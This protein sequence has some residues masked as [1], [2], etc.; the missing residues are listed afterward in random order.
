MVAIAR[1]SLVRRLEVLQVT[2]LVLVANS[3]DRVASLVLTR[4]DFES[5]VFENA[6]NAIILFTQPNCDAC[7]DFADTWKRLSVKY[8]NSNSVFVGEIS[9]EGHDLRVCDDHGVT[10]FPSIRYFH[11]GTPR[12][13]VTYEDGVSFVAVDNFIERTLVRKCDPVHPKLKDC[14]SKEIKYIKEQEHS[15]VE[16]RARELVRLSQVLSKSGGRG[17]SSKLESLH[18]RI[19]ILRALTEQDKHPRSFGEK[20]HAHHH[21]HS[22][23]EL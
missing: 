21:S 18:M 22:H 20:I 10:D 15:S 17:L 12:T 19:V 16:S 8:D 9:C 14:G 1:K 6:Q 11:P 13:A 2:F 23:D 3:F 4:R 5:H 7:D